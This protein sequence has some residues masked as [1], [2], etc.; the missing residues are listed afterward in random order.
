MKQVV[1]Q[2]VIPNND[3]CDE[4]KETQSGVGYLEMEGG[5]LV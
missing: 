3:T 4:N 5:E 2:T 1:M